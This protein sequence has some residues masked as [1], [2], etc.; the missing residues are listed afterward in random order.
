MQTPLR[1]PLFQPD[2]RYAFVPGRGFARAR[3]EL[4]F[5]KTTLPPHLQV[6]RGSVPFL[7]ICDTLMVS[8]DKEVRELLKH[9][10]LIRPSRPYPD[11]PTI[12]E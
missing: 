7:S 4:F 9:Y 10:M 11:S 5:I 8:S 6:G 12:G 1:R 2:R 3:V